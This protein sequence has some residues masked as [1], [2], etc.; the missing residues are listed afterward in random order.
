[1]TTLPLRKQLSASLRYL[2]ARER[3]SAA[4]LSLAA[5]WAFFYEYLPPFK[6]AHFP[7]DIEGFHFPLLDYAFRSLREG[8]FPLWDPDRKSVV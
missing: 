4:L 3:L 8:R 6:R 7:Y 2:A 1:M 5:G